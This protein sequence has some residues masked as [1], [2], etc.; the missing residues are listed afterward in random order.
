LFGVP[1]FYNRLPFGGMIED[2]DNNDAVRYLPEIVQKTQSIELI[3]DNLPTRMIRGYYTIRSN[4]L[5][6]TPFVGGKVNNTI[7]PICGVVNKINNY[8]DFVFGE[9]SSLVFTIT[10][11]LKLAS[12][13]CSIHDPDG[14]YARCNEQSTILF[15]IQKDLRVSFNV[16]QDILQEQEQQK[17]KKK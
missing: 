16:I 2:K 10:K 8:G 1:L 11:P 4:I 5:Q 7:M 17:Q 9:E 3:A 13:T 14:S 12:L 6:N 15:K